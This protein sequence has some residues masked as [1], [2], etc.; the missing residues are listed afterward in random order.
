[1]HSHLQ[2]GFTR[3]CRGSGRW[4]MCNPKEGYY[5]QK[6]RSV[7]AVRRLVCFEEEKKK[8]N[9]QITEQQSNERTNERTNGG[10]NGRTNERR[11]ERRKGGT[12][13]RTNKM[14]WA[15]LRA[16]LRC[17]WRCANLQLDCLGL[18]SLSESSSSLCFVVSI[19]AF[20]IRI[21]QSTRGL[22]DVKS[23]RFGV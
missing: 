11:N 8:N 22:V 6:V 3:K 17:M 7:V 19:V 1:M 10:T 4:K 18:L 14:C 23:S 2:W 5:V 20:T 16:A 21:V 15:A 9:G 12:E 13:E